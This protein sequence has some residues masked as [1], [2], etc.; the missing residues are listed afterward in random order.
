MDLKPT[1]M[2]RSSGTVSKNESPAKKIIN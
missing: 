2:E 1:A